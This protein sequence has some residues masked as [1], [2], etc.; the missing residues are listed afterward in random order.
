MFE[1]FATFSVL[2][3]AVKASGHS[4]KSLTGAVEGNGRPV[5]IYHAFGVNLLTLVADIAMVAGCTSMPHGSVCDDGVLHWRR[6]STC[7]L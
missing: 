2:I 7:H 5:S 1:R 6:T 4:V 3:L